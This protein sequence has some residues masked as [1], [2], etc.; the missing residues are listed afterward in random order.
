MLA[1]ACDLV[2]NHC[3][4][5]ASTVLAATGK[6]EFSRVAVPRYFP[7]SQELTASTSCLDRML[8]PLL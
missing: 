7:R 8:A 2:F 1:L 4:G 3:E 5:D 6:K